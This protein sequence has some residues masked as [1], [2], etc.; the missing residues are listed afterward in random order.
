MKNVDVQIV[1]RDSLV[2][3][4][5]IV[6]DGTLEPKRRVEEFLRQIKASALLPFWKGCCEECL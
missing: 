1:D 6:I 2:D 5:E 4:N 3:I